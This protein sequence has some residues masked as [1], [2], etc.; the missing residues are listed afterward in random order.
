MPTDRRR[1][2]ILMHPTSLPSPYGI[3]DLGP[4]AYAFVD[5]LVEMGQ[6]LWQVLPI[7]P[8]SFG[9]SPYFS[10]SAFAGNTNLISPDLLKQEGWLTDEELSLTPAFPEGRVDYQRVV[11]FKDGLL[12]RATLSFYENA[13]EVQRQE[14]IDFCEHEAEWLNDYALF[15]AIKDANGGR[16][17]TFWPEKLLHRDPEALNEARWRWESRVRYYQLGQYFFFKQWHELKRYANERGLA[18]IGDLPI[19]VAHDSADVWAE[20][21]LWQLYNTGN[22]CVVAGVPPDYFSET[23]QLWGN[24]LYDWNKLKETGYAWWMRRVSCLL[25]HV[26]WIRL[27]HFRGF[28]AYWEVP[29]HEKTAVNGRWVNGPGLDFFRVLTEK[30]GELPIIAEDLGL[31]TPDVVELRDTYG[32]P[33]MKILQF[34]FDTEEENNYFPHR[35]PTNAVVYTGTHDN[36]TTV[37]WYKKAN[38]ETQALCQE[39]IGKSDIT[40]PNW[41]L[42]RLAHASVANFS[43]IPLQDLLGLDSFARMNIPGSASGNWSWRLKEW[44]LLPEIQMRFGRMTKLYERNSNV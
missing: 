35:Y 12:D 43:I 1:S 38:P 31:I 40:E 44:E 9:D 27:D 4:T 11:P 37:G 24:P 23:G 13:S 29:A 32:F 21:L 30:M 28:A 10:P 7:T 15:M 34:A 18:I 5:S 2:G 6:T 42:I 39:Y 25:R 26:D 19:F 41:D 20:P 33:G 8:T 17:W 3:G 16:P 22:P 14:F 36:D